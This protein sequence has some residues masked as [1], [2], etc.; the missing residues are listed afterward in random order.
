LRKDDL[1]GGGIAGF[2]ALKVEKLANRE[3]PLGRFGQIMIPFLRA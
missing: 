2:A 3:K 1:Q